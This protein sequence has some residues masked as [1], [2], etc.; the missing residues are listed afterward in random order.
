M[1]SLLGKLKEGMD[2]VVTGAQDKI[3]EA[4]LRA[5]LRTTERE[6]TDQL[7]ALGVALYAM[8]TAGEIHLESLD[9]QM[10][11]ITEIDKQLK[12]RQD[13]IDQYLA[14]AGTPTSTS[15]AAGPPADSAN[16]HCSCGAVLSPAAKFCPECGKPNTP[17]GI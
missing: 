17:E 11:Q 6:K 3:H 7:T 15:T 14:T 4:Q 9:A 10:A 16:R 5:Q 1:S 13:E 8:Y 12:D 2:Q